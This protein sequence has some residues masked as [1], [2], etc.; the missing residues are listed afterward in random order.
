MLG[1]FDSGLGGLTAVKEIKALLPNESLI[2]FGDTSRVPYGSRSAETIVRYSF[3]DTRFLMSYNVDA[4]LIACGTVSSTALPQL[5]ENFNI[6][7]IGV[8]ESACEAAVKADKNKKIAVIGTPATIKSNSYVRYLNQICP[9]AEIISEA[10]PLFVPLVENGFTDENDPVTTLVAEKYLANIKKSGAD[11][12][13]LGCTHYPIIEKL[14]SKLLPGVTL[15]NSG[16][17]AA[18]AFGKLLAEKKLLKNEENPKEL[19]F[20]SDETGGFEK[21]A[22][23]F[24]GEDISNKLQKADIEKY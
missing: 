9:E 24:L 5:K 14:I 10:C 1:V 18:K 19:Y 8:V 22:S 21:T 7:I 2:Y 12:L 3:Q 11:T 4:I 20:V 16:K 6:P 17:E 23:L 15:I 13:I